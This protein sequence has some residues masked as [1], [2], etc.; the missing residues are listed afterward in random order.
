MPCILKEDKAAYM[1]LWRS[2]NPEKVAAINRQHRA[3]PGKK[4]EIAAKE[5]ERYLRLKPLILARNKVWRQ[6]NP[7]KCRA[8]KRAEQKRNPM[9][10]LK[11]QLRRR[12]L[13]ALDRA[14]ATK[15]ERT[16]E[17]IGCTPQFLKEH[18]E[19]Q[20]RQ[21]MSWANRHLWHIDHK[22]PC[23]AFDLTDPKQQM[24]CFHYTNLQPL[25]AMENIKKG[26][27]LWTDYSHAV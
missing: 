16:F 1:R 19:K 26:E 23:A 13:L 8:I 21:G 17:L 27:R 25:W 2:R 6:N 15:A 7:E 12:V 22:Q 18:L 24:A 14:K 20:F 11:D 5:K 3:I 4:E 9:V 10:R